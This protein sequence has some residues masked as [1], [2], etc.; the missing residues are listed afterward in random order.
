M[1]ETGTPGFQLCRNFLFSDAG[2]VASF[3]FNYAC[4][5][6][7][8]FHF[9]AEKSQFLILH[10]TPFIN[11]FPQYIINT[12]RRPIFQQLPSSSKN[13]PRRLTPANRDY[14]IP[15][16]LCMCVCVCDICREREVYLSNNP[17]LST[18]LSVNLPENAGNIIRLADL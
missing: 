15:T 13:K 10:S 12:R 16:D 3:G 1:A 4:R 5:K 2:K 17:S 8:K 9:K 11:K 14:D 18:P 6:N 7:E